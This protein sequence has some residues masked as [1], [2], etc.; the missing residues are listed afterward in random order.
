MSVKKI[1]VPEGMLKAAMAVADEAWDNGEI[2]R[3]LVGE[4]PWKKTS[5]VI[6]EAALRWLIGELPLPS[7]QDDEYSGPEWTKGYNRAMEDVRRM[8]LAPEPEVPECL[9]G[10]MFSSHDIG[11]HLKNADADNLS[12]HLNSYILEAY[13]MGRES[14]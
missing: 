12:N 6:L 10:M 3:S 5:R 9:E 8:F 4:T 14:K 11:L 7:L 2:G 13:R 1:V